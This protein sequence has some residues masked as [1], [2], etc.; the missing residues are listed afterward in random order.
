[1]LLSATQAVAVLITLASTADATARAGPARL[2]RR[3]T[4]TPLCYPKLSKAIDILSIE[5]VASS[6]WQPRM[7]G[8]GKAFTAV[9]LMPDMMTGSKQWKINAVKHAHSLPGTY[10][11]TA[12]NQ[13]MNHSREGCASTALA[14]TSIPG[15][16]CAADDSAPVEWLVSCTACDPKGVSASNCQLKSSITGLCA[17]H[18]SG[19]K[20]TEVTMAP[21][22]ASDDET[23]PQGWLL[24]SY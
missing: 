19:D 21:C 10:T 5:D 18:V 24:S 11:I 6:Y 1:M 15:S 22:L 23:F 20:N 2:A 16:N 8:M 12:L 4:S 17:Q 7:A 13:T 9:D 3:G 14:H